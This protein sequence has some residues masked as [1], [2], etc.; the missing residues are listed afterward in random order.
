M[1]IDD[2]KEYNLQLFHGV[3]H[4][5]ALRANLDVPYERESTL[6]GKR[7]LLRTMLIL[8]LGWVKEQSLK[9]IVGYCDFWLSQ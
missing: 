8:L 5:F 7:S 2:G 4:G 9:S 1:M 3:A 6:S